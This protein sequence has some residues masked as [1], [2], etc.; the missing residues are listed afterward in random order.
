MR[1]R[2]NEIEYPDFASAPVNTDD[3]VEEAQAA[4]ALIAIV[5]KVYDE[6]SPF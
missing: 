5:E 3:V 4:E 1:R 6:M 2:R